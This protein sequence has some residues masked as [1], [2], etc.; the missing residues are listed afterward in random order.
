MLNLYTVIAKLAFIVVHSAI[1]HFFLVFFLPD[2][3][4]FAVEVDDHV[5][6]H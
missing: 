6:C 4:M 1:S 3:D 5:G 2:C